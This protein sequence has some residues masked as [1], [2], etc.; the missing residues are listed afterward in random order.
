MQNHPCI[1]ILHPHLENHGTIYFIS[2]P[3]ALMI[4]VND[5]TR[6]RSSLRNFKVTDKNDS[7]TR[8]LFNFIT[9]TSHPKPDF[10]INKTRVTGRTN[11]IRPETTSAAVDT[12]TR[13][14]GAHSVGASAP[15]SQLSFADIF[16]SNS[17]KNGLI[18]IIVDEETTRCCLIWWKKRLKGTDS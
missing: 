2:P 18:P 5:I 14:L 9:T 1:P 12:R 13:T 15:S 4:P 16:R 11:S 8:A 10:I 17:L 6:I 3:R 7:P